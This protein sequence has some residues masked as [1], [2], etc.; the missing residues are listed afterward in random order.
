MKVI[1]VIEKSVVLDTIFSL[2]FTVCISFES[3]IL[4]LSILGVGESCNLP[5]TY[6]YNNNILC[7]VSN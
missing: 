7:N 1:S 5:Y 6:I 2:D 3:N 4:T